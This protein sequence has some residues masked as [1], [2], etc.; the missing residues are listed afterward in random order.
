MGLKLLANLSKDSLKSLDIFLKR[1][2]YYILPGS[3]IKTAYINL[4]DFMKYLLY[5]I[6][7][8]IVENRIYN[9][10]SNFLSLKE[11]LIVK[12]FRGKLIPMN[13]NKKNLFL[14][15]LIFFKKLYTQKIQS[16]LSI[17]YLNDTYKVEQNIIIENDKYFRKILIYDYFKHNKK[18]I[19]HNKFSIR[20]FIKKISFNITL[21]DYNSFNE[22]HKYLY[23][24]KINEL[25]NLNQYSSKLN[26]RNN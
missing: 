26:E 8:N 22:N 16:F 15:I 2:Y 23:Y 6:K 20:K 19:K 5:L 14:K 13:I 24:L 4:N 17:L 1:A 18:F 7:N 12:R 9:I 10:Y 21:D 11:L 3:N 25:I